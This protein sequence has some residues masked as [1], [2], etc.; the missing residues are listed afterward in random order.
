MTTKAADEPQGP[1][2]G[3]QPGIA[4]CLSGGGYRAMVFH[5][6]YAVCDA[7]MQAYLDTTLPAPAAFP[8]PAQG[9]G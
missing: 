3:P 4:L 2:P 9:V 7:A 1:P 6:G 8:Y 5:V